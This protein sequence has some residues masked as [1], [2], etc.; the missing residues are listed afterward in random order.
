MTFGSKQREKNVGTQAARLARNVQTEILGGQWL[1]TDTGRLY[2][3]VTTAG[4]DYP[5]TLTHAW[6]QIGGG[7]GTSGWWKYVV[8][9]DVDINAP[10]TTIATAIADALAAGHGPASPIDILIMPAVQYVESLTLRPGINLRALAS[11]GSESATPPVTIQGDH[12]IADVAGSIT[13]EGISFVDAAG[14]PITMAGVSDIVLNVLRCRIATP[15]TNGKCLD[16]SNTG[17]AS[18]INLEDSHLVPGAAGVGPFVAVTVPL[19]AYRTWFEGKLNDAML[20]LGVGTVD[21]LYD[22][23]T[24]GSILKESGILTIEGGVLDASTPPAVTGSAAWDFRN[25]TAPSGLG[26]S[27]A[28]VQL[29]KRTWRQHTVTALAGPTPALVTT[30]MGDEI[31]LTVALDEELEVQLPSLDL[32]LDGAE[33]T[34]VVNGT[35]LGAGVAVITT[36]TPDVGAGGL[37]WYR[38]YEGGTVTLRADQANARW[39]IVAEKVGVPQAPTVTLD[40]ATGL[41]TNPGTVAA[42]VATLARAVEIQSQATWY[43]N[44]P[45]AM[46][47]VA[48]GHV[49]DLAPAGNVTIVIPAAGHPSAAP[50]EIRGVWVTAGG[51]GVTAVAGRIASTAAPAW[52]KVTFAANPVFATNAA[53]N[54]WA[55]ITGGPLNGQHTLI[56][57]SIATDIE[58]AGVDISSAGSVSFV[59]ESPDNTIGATDVATFAGEPV[60]FNAIDAGLANLAFEGVATWTFNSLVTTRVGGGSLFSGSA[61]NI[62]TPPLGFYPL[63]TGDRF[64]GCFFSSLTLGQGFNATASNGV[65]NSAKAQLCFSTFSN[66]SGQHADLFLFHCGQLASQI[67]LSVGSSLVMSQVSLAPGSS[68]LVTVTIGSSALLAAVVLSPAAGDAIL[69][70]ENSTA[71][72]SA[73]TGVSA[74]AGTSGVRTGMLSRVHVTDPNV[75]TTVTGALGDVFVGANAVTTW[76]LIAAGAAANVND[77]GAGN[78]QMCRVSV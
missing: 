51:F 46:I 60:V 66:V 16:V 10:Y 4:A 18:E 14:A 61:T 47:S 73:V 15:N 45:G 20:Q 76:A 40:S 70:S 64:G 65:T 29:V 17:V 2:E 37:K 33:Y 11:T 32:I 24:F 12:A 19:H 74:V 55:L 50:L 56:S 77:L 43:G 75:G 9:P 27:D 54:L 48:S 68:G 7:S 8:S 44:A 28:T 67:T 21:E 59:V 25:V 42:P 35:A 53:S 63:T 57:S 34:F 49:E 62:G 30:E 58:L 5:A 36:V 38:L 31:A 78:P 6:L 52:E 71:T 22:C 3:V 69:V 41:D 39:E 72:I 23:K 13:L 26:F 1:E